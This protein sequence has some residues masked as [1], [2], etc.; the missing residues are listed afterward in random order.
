MY[1]SQI[2]QD[3]WVYSV[4]GDKKKGY[5][6]EIGA[7]NGIDLSNTFFFEK[8]LQ[9][10]GICVEPNPNFKDELAELAPSIL[11]LVLKTNSTNWC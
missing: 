10:D 8:T 4:I 1:K 3:K 5:F 2:G 7:A 6:I 9:W 11:Q